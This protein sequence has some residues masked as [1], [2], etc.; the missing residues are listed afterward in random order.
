MLLSSPEWQEKGPG[1]LLM[2]LNKL[3]KYPTQFATYLVAGA[4]SAGLSY[5][6]PD[7]AVESIFDTWKYWN[8]RMEREARRNRGRRL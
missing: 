1:V 5:V 4:I 3:A 8:E 6:V 7:N 2:H